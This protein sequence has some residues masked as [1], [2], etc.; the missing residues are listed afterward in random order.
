MPVSCELLNEMSDFLLLHTILASEA[1]S[2]ENL[3]INL[4]SPDLGPVSF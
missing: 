2:A 4:S 1:D 3:F